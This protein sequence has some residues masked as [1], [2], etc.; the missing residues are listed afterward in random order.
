M[1]YQNNI[2]DHRVVLESIE[3]VNM[4]TSINVTYID[5]RLFPWKG[6][7][8]CLSLQC[9]H[10]KDRHPDH[11]WHGFGAGCPGECGGHP[12]HCYQ[13][14]EAAHEDGPELCKG[15]WHILLTWTTIL[16]FMSN[17]EYATRIISLHIPENRTHFAMLHWA[18]SQPMRIPHHFMWVPKSVSSL[19]MRWH[20][21]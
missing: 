3:T 19:I 18:D 7:V 9:W 20:A 16:T 10:R 2:D 14:E 15:S 4:T 17:C 6:R 12:F 21:K 5:V 13:D 1:E 11:C 8:V